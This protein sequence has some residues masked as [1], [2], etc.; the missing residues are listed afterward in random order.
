MTFPVLG[1]ARGSITL[2][3]TKKTTFLLLESGAPITVFCADFK[4]NLEAGGRWAD[5]RSRAADNVIGYRGSGS[6]QEKKRAYSRN[7]TATVSRCY[8]PQRVSRNDVHEYEPL[9]WLETR[10]VIT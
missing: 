9:A 6:K 10:Q 2:L 5:A 4:R 3:L 1:E 7:V 8:L